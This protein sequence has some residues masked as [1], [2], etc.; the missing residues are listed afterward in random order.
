MDIESAARRIREDGYT[1]V[2]DFLGEEVLDGVLRGLAPVF[3]AVG[4][5]MTEDY[6]QQTIHTHNLLAKTR[7]VVHGR[8]RGHGDR[9]RQPSLG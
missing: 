4:S 7:A 1:V 8:E 5:R 6:G 2:P 3:D 9:P